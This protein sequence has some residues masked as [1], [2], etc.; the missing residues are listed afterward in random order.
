MLQMVSGTREQLR[1]GME[2]SLA[3]YRHRVF[4]REL[5]W[6]LQTED[7]L[8]RDA[9]DRADTLYVVAHDDQGRVCGCGRLLPTSGPYLLGE[10]FPGLMG[11]IPLPR[12]AQIWELS[13]FAIST[14]EGMRLT[15]EQAWRNTCA[16]MADIVRVASEQ[17]AERL[18]AFSA[19]GNER[20]LRR[21]GVNVH[22][23]SA[24]QL[25]DGKPV[26]AFWIE[27]D[28]QTLSALG[29]TP[30]RQVDAGRGLIT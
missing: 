30:T 28:E 27:I 22:R 18:I 29:I 26:L 15:G 9:F 4:I 11:D 25:I 21:M 1:G 20:L 2:V 17:G 8:E 19:V 6:P 16:L 14:P 7:G 3:Q 13:R 23:V 12:S 10:V 5:G 24:P